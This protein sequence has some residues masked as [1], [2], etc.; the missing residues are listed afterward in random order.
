MPYPDRQELLNR[1]YHKQ[2]SRALSNLAIA[3][4]AFLEY[5][6]H[7][8]AICTLSKT[9]TPDV[10]VVYTYGGLTP[11]HFYY[12]E[13]GTITDKTFPPYQQFT[14]EWIHHW[15]DNNVAVAILDVPDYF[16]ANG[17][18]WVSSFYR[19]SADRRR[20]SLQAIDL[21]ANK[22]PNAKLTWF[23]IS[24]GVGDAVNISLVDSR[25]YKIA[26]ASG[27]WHVLNNLDVFHQGQRLDGYDVT[28][29]KTPVLIIQHEKEVWEK[30][31]D[32]MSKTESLLV[33]NNVSEDDGHFFRKRQQ[34]VV[35]AICDWFRDK[36]I[37]K[38]I[39]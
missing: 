4:L 1:V 27:C 33:T 38:I 20:E 14:W 31:Q 19:M 7:K 39:P 26:M 5:P 12:Q 18:G 21:L 23:G 24:Y 25:L 13:D 37:P 34:E 32:Q 16:T 35:T 30:A 17:I 29:S 15:L 6:N 28:D 3:E 2:R 8:T 11:H 9:S 10:V 22:F 36:P